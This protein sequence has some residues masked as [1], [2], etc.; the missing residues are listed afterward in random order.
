M[1]PR[2]MVISLANDSE[3]LGFS[4]ESVG[5]LDTEAMEVAP[6]ITLRTAVHTCKELNRNHSGSLKVSWES[7][8]DFVR[9][10]N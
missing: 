3:Y 5:I 10:K 9:G 6:F 7:M 1:K 2:F 8:E 4:A